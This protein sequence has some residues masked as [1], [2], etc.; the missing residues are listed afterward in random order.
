MELLVALLIGTLIGAGVFCLLRR[1]VVKMVIGIIL[2]SQGANLLVFS[3]GGLQTGAP[4]LIAEGG[5][6]LREPYSDPLPQALV[7]TAI[8][9]GFGLI[10]FTLALVHRAYQSLGTDDI[11]AFKQTDQLK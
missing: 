5:K 8:V 6:M 10:A 11:N 9:I 3:A 1:S 7:L 4:P 2:F